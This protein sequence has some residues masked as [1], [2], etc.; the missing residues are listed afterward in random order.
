MNK[1]ITKIAALSVGLAMAIGVGVAVGS[2]NRAVSAKAE[3]GSW[4]LA[5]NSYSSS[6]TSAVVWS[7][8]QLTM[9]LNQGTAQSG[10][11]NYLGGGSNAHTRMYAGQYLTFVPASGYQINSVTMTAT[12]NSYCNYTARTNC[13]VSGSNATR[14]ITPTTKTTT[15]EVSCSGNRI[16]GVSFNYSEAQAE[17]SLTAITGISATITAVQGADEWTVSDLVVTGT[18]SVSGS[19]QDVTE[20]VDVSINTDVPKTTS[21]SYP[22]SVT[23]SKKSSVSGSASDYSTTINATVT[24]N[25]F[26]SFTK[27]DDKDD[28]SVNGIYALSNDGIRFVGNSVAS[29]GL[30]YPI[31]D[32]DDVGFFKLNDSGNLQLVAKEN[33]VWSGGESDYINNTSSAN[34]SKGTATSVWE[35]TNDGEAGVMLSNTTFNNRFLG[36]GTSDA[37]TATIVKAY[38][39]SNLHQGTDNLPVYLYEVEML[40]SKELSSIALSGTY[41]TTFKQGDAF[42]HEGM[43]V[44]ATFDDESQTDVTSDA[45]WTGYNMSTVGNQTVTVSYTYEGTTKTATYGITISES[46]I[47]SGENFDMEVG[48][49]DVSPVIKIKNTETVVDGC[50][51]TSSNTNVATIVNNKVHAV[52]RGTS[53][54]TASHAD[55]NNKTYT[56]ATFTVTVIKYDSIQDIYSMTNGDSVD[57]FGYY[58]GKH[59]DGIILMDGA[60]GMIVFKGASENTWTVD[61][62]VIH[63]TGTKTSY[64]GLV[65]VAQG[66][67][68]TKLSG[69]EETAAKALISA[70]TNY[71]LTGLETS[72]STSLANRRTFVSGTLSSISGSHYYVEVAKGN[73]T[74]TVDLYLK[75]GNDNTVTY[76]DENGDP[77]T[78]KLSQYLTNMEGE[79]VTVKGFT[80]IYNTSFQ[81]LAYDI[82]EADENYTAEQFAQQLLSLTDAVC[83]NYD[84]HTNNKSALQSIWNDLGGADYWQKLSGTEQAIFTD[85][86]NPNYDPEA[87]AQHSDLE[88]AAGRYDIL[89]KKYFSTDNFASRD[90]SAAPVTPVGAYNNGLA[91]FSDNG[92]NATTAIIVISSVTLLG[93]GGYFFIRK[94]K[95]Q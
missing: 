56:N 24:A 78:C 41:P 28:V 54:I 92:M 83:E 61:E 82:V 91:N 58:A 6:S 40:A 44:T 60:F 73:D 16:T 38:A 86:E 53:T 27:V 30:A 21:N 14:T 35:A 20:K 79:K 34:I 49:T 65:E 84:G 43:T 93:V 8:T 89:C 32:I 88:N 10:A 46:I 80:S 18:L 81:I 4:N 19:G 31:T 37:A 50:T 70:P 77:Q 36:L 9:T 29:S 25:P 55:A 7:S 13:T 63:V 15:F 51:F 75:S 42:S 74:I 22:V 69:A 67:T 66:A 26:A 95:E 33:D 68:V 57:F 71:T 1:F 47:L 3:T 17:E 2:G 90:T 72:A 76:H 12:G 94:K 85:E 23:A 52:A 5:T 59:S 39:T 62:S 45:T 48:D 87:L 64:N 11:N